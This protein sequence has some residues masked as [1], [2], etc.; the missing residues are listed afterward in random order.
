MVAGRTGFCALANHRQS[1]RC[2]QPSVRLSWCHRIGARIVRGQSCVGV[3]GANR[4]SGHPGCPSARGDP[5]HA[6]YMRTSGGANLLAQL[7]V[8]ATELE[9]AELCATTPLTG[10]PVPAL[11]AAL[12]QPLA[13][14]DRRLDWRVAELDAIGPGL[15][16]ATIDLSWLVDHWIVIE[17]TTDDGSA[18][19]VVDPL[20]GRIRM[21][22]DELRDRLTGVV[23]V[24]EPIGG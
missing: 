17:G 6:V 20:V 5:I 2:T 9:L 15:T 12:E 11:A 10:T 16:L 19:Q 24:V 7:G 8:A 23:L 3:R 21:T 4:R 14:I 13:S 18:Y 22:R 1:H